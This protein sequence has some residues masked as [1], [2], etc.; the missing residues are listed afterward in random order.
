M[1]Y[2]STLVLIIGLSSQVNAD[3]LCIGTVAE[4]TKWSESWNR[5]MSYSLDVDGE[6]TP[7]IQVD[8]DETRTMILTAYAAQKTLNIHWLNSPNITACS[9][10][11]SWNHY[12]Q[13]VGYITIK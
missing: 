2:I 11:N 12:D 8:D 1:K 6:R 7:F 10:E 13:L 5:N 4:I 3:I 9:G